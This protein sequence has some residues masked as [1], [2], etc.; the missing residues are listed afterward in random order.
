MEA[1]SF[2]IHINCRGKFACCRF[3]LNT[4]IGNNGDG[5]ENRNHDNNNKKFNDGKARYNYSL[6]LHRFAPF[7]FHIK[8]EVT[9]NAMLRSVLLVW[10]LCKLNRGGYLLCLE[11]SKESRLIGLPTR[12]KNCP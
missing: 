6:P 8:N 1:D 9:M 4:V 7:L 10:F 11:A 12:E 2:D 3:F 5:R